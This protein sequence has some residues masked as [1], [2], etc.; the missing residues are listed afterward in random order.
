MK[1]ECFENGRG[2]FSLCDGGLYHLT[3]IFSN[4][5]INK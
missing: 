1:N 5:T 2:V 4:H 3:N